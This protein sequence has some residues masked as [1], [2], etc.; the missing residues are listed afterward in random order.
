MV[1]SA[2]VSTMI[3]PV[4]ARSRLGALNLALVIRLIVILAVLGFE[5][6]DESDGQ[7]PAP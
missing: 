7:N 3:M 5:T 6:V 4:A 1:L 2:T